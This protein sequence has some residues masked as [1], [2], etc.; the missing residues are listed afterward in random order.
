MGCTCSQGGVHVPRGCTWYQVGV[1]CPEGVCC[2]GC[3]LSWGMYLVPGGVYLVPTDIC[4]RGCVYLAWGLHLVPRGCMLQGFFFS[5]GWCLLVGGCTWSGIFPPVDSKMPVKYITFATSLRTLIIIYNLLYPFTTCIR[6][7]PRPSK[8][9]LIL[10]KLCEHPHQTP[11]ALALGYTAEGGCM[12][13]HWGTSYMGLWM[14]PTITPP[15]QHT[16]TS[17]WYA[18][19]LNLCIKKPSN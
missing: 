7:D 18:S 12:F 5:R 19:Y 4:C 9:T 14:T 15:Q 2:R 10:P 1:P 6:K 17:G 3:T 13:T 11:L 8:H 16:S